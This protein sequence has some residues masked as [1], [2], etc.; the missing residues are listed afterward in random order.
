MGREGV[1]SK[2]ETMEGEVYT[3]YIVER[4]NEHTLGSKGGD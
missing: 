3:V 2:V 1:R 4:R